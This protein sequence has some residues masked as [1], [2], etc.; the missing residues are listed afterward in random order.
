MHTALRLLML[1]Q[2]MHEQAAAWLPI[3]P[4]KVETRNGRTYFYFVSTTR[5]PKSWVRYAGQ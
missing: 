1:V 5:K 2:E 3:E 4:S